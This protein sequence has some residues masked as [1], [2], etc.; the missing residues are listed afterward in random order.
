[1]GEDVGVEVEVFSARLE[2]TVHEPVRD[3]DREIC[4][5][6]PEEMDSELFRDLNRADC[7]A[8]AE[9]TVNEAIK[10]TPMLLV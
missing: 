9:L 6:G 10:F 2:S 3:L 8:T 7:I 5:P 4:P 1:M